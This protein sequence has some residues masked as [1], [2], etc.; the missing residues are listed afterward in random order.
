MELREVIGRRRSIRFLRPYKAVERG[1]IQK[2]LE[3][4]RLASFWGNVQ[5]LK[6]VVIERSSAPPEVVA[7][8]PVGTAI[9]GF[10]FRSAPVVIVWCLDWQ[11]VA[12]QG[13]RLHELV[14][15]GALGVDKAKSHVYLPRQHADS[16]LQVCQRTDSRRR[17][18]RD[19][20]WAGHR[21]GD[22]G[23]VRGGTWHLPARRDERSQDAK[24]A[25]TPREHK[26]HC[27][28]DCG[29]SGGRSRR[30]RS[31]SAVAVRAQIFPQRF[32][33]SVPTRS[34][35]RRGAYRGQDASGAGTPA[36][37]QRGT[38]LAGQSLRT[39]RCV[40]RR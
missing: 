38:Q 6:T 30:G 13:D 7:A 3:A 1:K 17:I 11:A 12:E 27:A 37:P 33:R 34:Q 32:W 21:S 26:D 24:S 40:W 28:S 22:A 16:V 23:R 25:Q 4:A 39:G 2:M 9:G 15:A 31:T 8:L 14:D 10:Q 19:R 29:L 35:G 18:H 36:R 5:A 20:L